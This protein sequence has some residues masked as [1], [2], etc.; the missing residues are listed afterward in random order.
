MMSGEI[1]TTR[2]PTRHPMYVP[3]ISL[4]AVLVITPCATIAKMYKIIMY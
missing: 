4:P 2:T 3:S 1:K